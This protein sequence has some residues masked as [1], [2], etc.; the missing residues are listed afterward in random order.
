VGVETVVEITDKALTLQKLGEMVSSVHTNLDGAVVTFIGVVR[1]ISEG[2]R[3]LRLE[4]ETYA[5]MAE[6]QLKRLVEE[7]KRRWGARA[8]IAHRVGNVEVGQIS[9]IIVVSSPHRAEAFEGCR[10]AIERIKEVAPI[11][12]KEVYEDGEEWV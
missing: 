9:V 12:K 1:G 5:K 3:V 2:K 8:A 6:R 4:Y 7:I 11:W 10:Y